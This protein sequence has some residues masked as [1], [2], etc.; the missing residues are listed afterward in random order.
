MRHNFFKNANELVLLKY[1]SSN[2]SKT[3]HLLSFSRSWLFL[4]VTRGTDPTLAVWGAQQRGNRAQD[5]HL[6]ACLNRMLCRQ[7]SA[8]GRGE[9][10]V[11]ML[12][13][14]TCCLFHSK[15]PFLPTLHPKFPSPHSSPSPVD[16][17]GISSHLPNTFLMLSLI[18]HR[19]HLW[20]QKQIF[21]NALSCVFYKRCLEMPFL[22][23]VRWEGPR[24]R[25]YKSQP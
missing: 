18:L 17:V 4:R 21:S 13:L 20:K 3:W 7:Q 2:P 6:H 8:D 24:H 16:R 23:W 15:P 22:S 14:A 19:Q 11:S 9:E 5:G 12:S 1:L 25:H 10:R